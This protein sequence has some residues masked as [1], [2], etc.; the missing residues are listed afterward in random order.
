MK[1]CP[2]D[3]TGNQEMIIVALHSNQGA[4]CSKNWKWLSIAESS[5]SYLVNDSKVTSE[6][7]NS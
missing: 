2:F 6:K 1:I 3:V 5:L 7:I 4:F